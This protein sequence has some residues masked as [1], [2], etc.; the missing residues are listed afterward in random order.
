MSE[1]TPIEWTDSTLNLMMGCDGCELWV[2]S[3][4][5]ARR[6]NKCYAGQQTARYAGR[7]GYPAKFSEPAVFAGR[8]AK[9]CTWKDLTGTKRPGK[10]WLDG[11]SRL[12]FLDDMGDTFTESLPLDWL[13]PHVPAMEA[14]PHVWQFL[15]KRPRRMRRFFEMLG[16]VPK[17]FWLGTSVTSAANVGRVAELVK[18]EG[19]GVL[20]ISAEPLLGPVSLTGYCREE[21]GGTYSTWLDR[22]DWVIVGGESGPKARPMHPDWAAKIRD[23]CARAGAAFFYK[24]TGEWASYTHGQLHADEILKRPHVTL[25]IDGKLLNDVDDDRRAA[26]MVRVGK[27]AAGR[28]LDG[29]EWSQMPGR[30][31]E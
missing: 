4:D 27:K 20:F 29:R 16:H 28:L 30:G 10:P 13:L 9:A 3:D 5:P 24:Q 18:I 17:N 23:D 31:R 14:S 15:T 8:L 11:L 7:K 22:L 19:A 25:D 21:G 1:N 12:I 26:L 6:V 2:E